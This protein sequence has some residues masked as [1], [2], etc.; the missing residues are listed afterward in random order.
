MFTKILWATDGSAASDGTLPLVK[1]LVRSE[2]AELIV[3]H[4]EPQLVGS[5]TYGY[6][7]YV[8]ED[9]IKDKIRRQAQELADAGIVAEA[10]IISGTT[11]GGVARDI[12][13]AAETHDADLVI[14]ATRGHTEVGGLLVGSVTHR[15]LHIASCPVL[16]LPVHARSGHAPS[17]DASASVSV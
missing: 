2:Q 6:P 12:A 3:F 7:V 11:W 14:V 15:L 4:S 10:V 5:L 17:T 13:S 16:V 8:E 1:E 9:E